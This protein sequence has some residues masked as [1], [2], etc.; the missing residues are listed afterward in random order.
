MTAMPRVLV[1]EDDPVLRDALCDTI[2]FGGF[3]VRAAGDGRE[4]L[5]LLG[6]HPVDLIVSDVQMPGM[7]GE[8][9]LRAVRAAHPKLPVVLMTAYGSVERA[10][11]A[12]RE[13][14]ADYLVKPFSAEVLLEKLLSLQ[15][16][17]LTSATMIAQDPAM[18]RVCSLADCVAES[19]A[20]V[21]ITGESG[22]GKEVLARYLHQRSP[23]S[24][25]PMLAINCAAIPENM[26]ES[27]LFGYEK[28]AY[29]GAYQARPGK[30]EQANGSTLLLDE[31]SEMDLALQAKILRVLQ[32]KEVERLGGSRPVRLDVRVIATTN[33]RLAEAVADGRFREDLYYRLMVFPLHL[34]PLRERPEDI[35]P[36]V[37]S[38]LQR[39]AASTTA[40]MGLSAA[41]VDKIRSHAW[42]GNVRELENC[43]QRALLLAGSG[44]IQAEHVCFAETPTFGG[45][46]SVD[47]FPEPATG[48]ALPAAVLSGELREKEQDLIIAA[49]QA[50]GGQR[51]VAAQAL[52]IS[53]RTLRYKLAKLREQ[54]VLP[55]TVGRVSCHE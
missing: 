51:S 33:R 26:L 34:P 29:T 24:A 54:G 5:A 3:P 42:R 23:R 16:S 10:V 53:P 55:P 32:E 43:I 40:A 49:L 46:G 17:N 12:M 20:T 7:T 18:R 8:G 30:F 41:V 11:S 6:R 39:Y 25:Q 28:G 38:F 37:E 9:L 52:G 48:P 21:L 44:P 31:I 14:A 50:A 15:P 27:I 45:R 2:A 22:T 36:L 1:V 4:A 35:L 13:G 47:P 19:D